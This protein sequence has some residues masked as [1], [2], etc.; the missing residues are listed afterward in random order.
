[1]FKKILIGAA[2]LSFAAAA[3]ANA[4]FTLTLF[5][6]IT[7]V[8]VDDNGV[9]DTNAAVGQIDFSGAIGIFSTNI[10]TGKSKPVIGSATFGQI[11]IHSMTV[12]SSAAGGG[13]TWS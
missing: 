13:V 4:A 12:T 10:A 11:S 5:D 1:M 6:G 8:I 3:P 9:G 7:G 2:L